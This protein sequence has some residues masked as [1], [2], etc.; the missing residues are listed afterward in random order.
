[1]CVFSPHRERERGKYTGDKTYLH[2][3]IRK[4]M[5]SIIVSMHAHN[6]VGITSNRPTCEHTRIVE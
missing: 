3:Q 2:A 5:L 1:M 4:D 6:V